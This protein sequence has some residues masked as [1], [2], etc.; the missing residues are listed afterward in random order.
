MMAQRV[1]IVLCFSYFIG[2]VCCLDCSQVPPDAFQAYILSS[3][4]SG[5]E[6][7]IIP[8]GGALT[9]LLYPD[10][11]GVTRDL[12]L[13]FDDP[14]LY[15]SSSAHPYFSVLIGRYANRIA[16]GTFQLDGKSYHTPLNDHDWD[17]LHGGTQG[18]DLRAWKVVS[19]NSTMLTLGYFSPDGEMG[20]P[21]N[22][23]VEV[24]YMIIDD[25]LIIHY[26]AFTDTATVI[27]LT[28]HT[29]WNFNG[30]ANN[31]QDVLD[32]VLYINADKYVQTDSHLIPTGTLVDV[33]KDYWMDFTTPKP[34]GKDISHGTVTPTGGYD[35]AWVL[36]P[37]PNWATVPSLTVKAPLTG[38]SAQL[39]TD[40]PSLQFY[41][42]NFLDSSI[43]RKAD[44][45]FGNTPQYYA[46]YGTVVFEA[47]KYPDSVNHP[48][49]PN[50]VIRKGDLYMQ[51]TK[52]KISNK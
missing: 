4:S 48:N 8:F 40:Q 44:Q 39:F 17:T 30:F 28:H 31:T 32:H 38:I 43:P 3:R 26:R 35:N 2:C 24:S 42:G 7:H 20:F 52:Y 1:V 18:F 51:T 21:G 16:N 36:K 50:T 25:E 12:V 14:T 45:V 49:F 34:V 23:W 9:H 22:L 27:N 13:G 6:A 33:A 29:Y 5:L 11:D 19:Y 37:N 41:S 46:H 10:R 15:C 47:Q